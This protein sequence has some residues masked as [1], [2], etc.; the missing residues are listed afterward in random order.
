MA[1]PYPQDHK[2]DHGGHEPGHDEVVAGRR[3]RRFHE[4]NVTIIVHSRYLIA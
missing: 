3:G 2:H 4:V 1:L